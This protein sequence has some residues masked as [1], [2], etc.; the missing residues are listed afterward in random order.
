MVKELVEMFLG[1]KRIFVISASLLFET[2]VADIDVKFYYEIIVWY[3]KFF[4]V[5]KIKTNLLF[6]NMK[7]AD[8]PISVVYFIFESYEIIL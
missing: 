8:I 3:L 5:F 4:L 6:T 1:C 7:R 2:D